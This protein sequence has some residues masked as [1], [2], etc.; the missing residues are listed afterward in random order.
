MD[1]KL[2]KPKVKGES[3]K[4]SWNLFKFLNK[5][6]SDKNYGNYYKNQL[7]ILWLHHSRWD[8]SYL[9]FNEDK[10]NIGQLII[11]PLGKANGRSFFSMQSVLAKGRAEEFAL[12]WREDELT[13][14]TD[15]FFTTYIRDGR[16]IFDRGHQSWLQGTENR[17]TFINNTRRCN[18]CGKWHNKEIQKVVS[19][20]RKEVW[21]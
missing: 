5:L 13:N 21:V 14:I 10:L 3:D 8:G 20:K 12:P 19:I 6:H 1:L 17:F 2:I 4:Y 7:E 9:E 18:W 15:W 16:C 11:M